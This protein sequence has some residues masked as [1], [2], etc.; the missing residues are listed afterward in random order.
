VLGQDVLFNERIAT[1]AVG[2]TQILFVDASTLTVGPNANMVID[3]FVYDPNAGTGKLAAS[4]TRGVSAL[5]AARSAKA[6]T[7]SRSAHR[8]RRSASAAGSCCSP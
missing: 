2:Q 1:S 7:P 3:Q 8:R 5:S 4:L 6:T